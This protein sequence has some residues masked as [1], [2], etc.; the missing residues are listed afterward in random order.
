[1]NDERAVSPV[2]GVVLM[3]SV[4][5]LLGSVVFIAANGI[6]ADALDT[7]E[8]PVPVSQNLL[9]NGGFES[10]DNGRWESGAD[11]G[12][13]EA[14]AAIVASNAHY[15]SYALEMDEG[16][17]FT[18]QNVT[19]QITEASTYRVCAWSKVE[20]TGSDAYVGVQYYD[21]SGDII[22]KETWKVTWTEYEQRCVLTEIGPDEGAVEAEVWA[23]RGTTGTGTP[24]LYVDDV[25]LVKMRYFADPDARPDDP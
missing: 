25:S 6:V 13:L 24:A 17:T 18:G 15:G 16:A 14:D 11:N 9:W 3:V 19:R 23:Y 12:V 8:K 1:M 2:I 21:E 20:A 7:N 22:E 5:V 4:S 10:G